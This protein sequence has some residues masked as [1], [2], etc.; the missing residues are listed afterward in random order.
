MTYPGQKFSNGAEDT[1]EK[2]TFISNN[3]P[4]HVLHG[5][6]IVIFVA[7]IYRSHVSHFL[8]DPSNGNGGTAGKL[9]CV[10]DFNQSCTVCNKCALLSVCDVAGNSLSWKLR[11]CRRCISRF[12]LCV[13]VFHV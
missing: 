12:K 13:H 11:Y 9:F 5:N 1:V 4:L 7:N 3:L 8:D 10:I 2:A 6:E